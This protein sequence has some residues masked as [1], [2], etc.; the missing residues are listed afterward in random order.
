MM[1]H[2]PSR[3]AATRAAARRP[4]LVLV[5]M[6]VGM[7][8]VQ[9]DVTVVNVALP[10]IGADVHTAVSGLQWVVDGYAVPFAALLLSGG[11]LGDRYGHR[12]MVIAGLLLFATGSAA[13]GLAPSIGA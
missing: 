12:H 13:C 10:T 1:Q 2:A 11:T 9:F 4:Y 7:F 3:S 6:C 8:L 5:T